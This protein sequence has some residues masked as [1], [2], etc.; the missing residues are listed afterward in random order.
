MMMIVKTI[1]NTRVNNVEMPLVAAS[2]MPNVL[3]KFSTFGMRK[4]A[5]TIAILKI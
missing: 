4:S 1:G 5:V 3:D 2:E